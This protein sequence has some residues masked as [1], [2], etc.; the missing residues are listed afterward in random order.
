MPS[1]LIK[2]ISARSLTSPDVLRGVRYPLRPDF[3]VAVPNVPAANLSG[4]NSGF[5][6]FTAIKP[7]VFLGA[8]AIWATAGAA[9]N[10]ARVKKVLSAATS[11]PGAAADTNNID[12]SAAIA[13]DATSNVRRDY[14]AV[15]TSNAHLLAA[16]DKVAIAS[17]GGVTLLV[18][19]TFVLQ[20]AWM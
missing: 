17:A 16:G 8:Q 7:C 2:G 3:F 10:T 5:W 18:G 9:G 14:A 19:A 1:S 20:F 12:I 13:L 11:A 4:A 15:T 6:V